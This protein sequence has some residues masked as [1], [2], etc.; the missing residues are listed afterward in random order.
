MQRVVLID[1]IS[2]G[3]HVS[4][5]RILSKGLRDNGYE[6][7][8]IGSSQL[9]EKISDLI[10]EGIPLELHSRSNQLT[11]EW[12]KFNFMNTSVKLAKK[13]KPDVIHFLYLDRF[14]WS[15]A[16]MGISGVQY[17]A[18][19]HWGYMLPE[20]VSTRYQKVR[21]AFDI[22]A[23]RRLAVRGIRI[24]VHSIWLQKSL[25]ETV[26]YPVFD[27]VPYPVELNN[28]S[29]SRI[30]ASLLKE[31][32]RL[33]KDSKL[34]LVF[35][36]TR[37]DKGADL[38][39]KAMSHLDIYWHLLVAGKP[40]TFN[41]DILLDIAR[42]HGVDERIHFYLEYIPE[43]YVADFFLA[44]DVVLLPY[45]SIFSGQSGPL[46]LAAYLGIPVVAASVP[47][48][49]ETV[50]R[51]NLGVLFPPEDIDGMIKAFHSLEEKPILGLYTDFRQDHSSDSFIKKC[52]KSYRN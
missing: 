1:P 33:P 40:D 12:E 39:V 10:V 45:R 43:E 27:Y 48:L 7:V 49:A 26:G 25:T 13:I 15:L 47:V 8:A 3:H 21:A 4:Y 32:F 37:Y 42:R 2:T 30:R 51:Y 38:A 24:M 22:W 31:R 19:L 23:L 17:R 34:A 35:G 52:I 28:L 9:L 14:V 5:A 50:E 20:F 6:V 18:T 36:G 29:E 11:M 16:M 44:S 41:E 46:M